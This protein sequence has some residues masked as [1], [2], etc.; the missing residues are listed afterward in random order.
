MYILH[1]I[2]L[3]ICTYSHPYLIFSFLGIVRSYLGRQYIFPVTGAVLEGLCFKA[4]A[5]VDPFLHISIAKTSPLGF[6]VSCR[7]MGKSEPSRPGKTPELYTFKRFTRAVR[8]YTPFGNDPGR[9]HVPITTS[10]LPLS[11][12]VAK[13]L[14]F[15][16]LPPSAISNAHPIAPHTWYSNSNILPPH[17]TTSQHE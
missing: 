3:T 8:K 4:H 17:Q 6:E 13:N 14:K 5:V 16:T 2:S 11:F 1:T 12:D 9:K 7:R 15:T 10:T